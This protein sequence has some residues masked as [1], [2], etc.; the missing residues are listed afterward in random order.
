MVVRQGGVLGTRGPVSESI[1]NGGPSGDLLPTMSP[2]VFG[3]LSGALG[4]ARKPASQGSGL[5]HA[6]PQTHFNIV[7]R[8]HSG[9]C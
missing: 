5:G 9:R 2:T 8:W 7:V 1:G 3:A 4:G 6:G